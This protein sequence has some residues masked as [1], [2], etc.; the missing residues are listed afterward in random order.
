MAVALKTFVLLSILLII[1]LLSSGRVEQSF[2][3]QVRI[4]PP[5]T[6]ENESMHCRKY[7]PRFN[8]KCGIRV[9]NQRKLLVPVLDYDDTGPNPKHDPRKKPPGHP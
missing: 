7:D 1:P 2:K 3:S 9:T 5:I 6:I 4:P 8:L